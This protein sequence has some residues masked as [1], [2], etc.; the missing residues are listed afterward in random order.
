[1][2][3]AIL[4]LSGII[5]FILVAVMISMVRDANAAARQVR[6]LVRFL[7]EI[8]AVDKYSEWESALVQKQS[9]SGVKERIL[10]Y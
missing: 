7:K 10:N 4:I 6:L 3:A 9:V 8:N 1:M 2:L 5:L